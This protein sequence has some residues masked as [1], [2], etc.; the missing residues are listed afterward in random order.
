MSIDLMRLRRAIH[1][2]VEALPG[3]RWLV[4]G[5]ERSHVVT[6]AHCDCID[7]AYRPAVQC[8]HMLAARLFV[9]DVELRDALREL[10]PARSSVNRAHAPPGQRG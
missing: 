2:R 10:V 4:D 1:L 9:L 3:D 6:G 5:G 7:A 8:A